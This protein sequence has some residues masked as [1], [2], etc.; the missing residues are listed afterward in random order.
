MLQLPH[1]IRQEDG[2]REQF[3]AVF[4]RLDADSSLDVTRAEFKRYFCP[5][6]EAHDARQR[7]PANDEASRAPGSPSGRPAGAAEAP[8]EETCVLVG[9]E[10]VL[11]RLYEGDVLEQA[12]AAFVARHGFD[13]DAVPLLME[14]AIASMEKARAAPEPL[15]DEQGRM[16]LVSLAVSLD[17]DDEEEG[18]EGAGGE[19][20]D[21]EPAP[22]KKKQLPPIVLFEG[23]TPEEA[24]TAYC[25]ANGLDAE[26]V[27]PQLADVLRQAAEKREAALAETAAKARSD[28]TLGNPDGSSWRDFSARVSAEC[29]HALPPKLGC[30]VA[31]LRFCEP[32]P[33]D[34]VHVDQAPKVGTTQSTAHA[35]VLQ[36]RVSAR[37]GH[38]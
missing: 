31:R 15:R 26:V 4:Q 23:Q 32:V 29:G 28:G 24:A 20:V 12:V 25:E 13:E 33:H 38:T 9:V 3:E 18:A 34:L 2:T 14:G 37:Y 5:L 35:A 22:K 6:D 27:G 16:A 36:L 30:T 11:L 17:V 19:D 7:A 21:A 8:R 1:H 10:S